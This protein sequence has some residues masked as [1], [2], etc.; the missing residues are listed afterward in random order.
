MNNETKLVRGQR[1]KTNVPQYIQTETGDRKENRLFGQGEFIDTC[2]L[3]A[4]AGPEDLEAFVKLDNLEGMV[5]VPLS[6]IQPVETPE[7]ATARREEESM[8]IAREYYRNSPVTKLAIPQIPG[9]KISVQSEDEYAKCFR[10]AG[11]NRSQKRRGLRHPY[12]FITTKV[13]EHEYISRLSYERNGRYGADYRFNVSNHLTDKRTRRY[14]H[15]ETAAKKLLELHGVYVQISERKKE[16][17]KAD[18][19]RKEAV[20]Q[21]MA[22]LLPQ[23]EKESYSDRWRLNNPAKG[24]SGFYVEP[25]VKLNPETNQHEF[26]GLFYVK[27][28]G[29]LTAEQIKGIFDILEG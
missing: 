4:G 2:C 7:E 24:A 23:A 18:Q 16:H 20:N 13:G 9:C 26:Q 29:R 19:E 17:E 27:H 10:T 15:I 6:I 25:Y 1:I 8:E 3:P 28:L 5:R 21:I 22:D 11:L 12:V 14:K